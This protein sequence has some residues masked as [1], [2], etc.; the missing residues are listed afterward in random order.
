VQPYFVSVL[1]P[2]RQ[3]GTHWETHRTLVA[4]VL[5]QVKWTAEPV[6]RHYVDAPGP[7]IRTSI[8]GRIATGGTQ[9]IEL[10]TAAHDGIVEAVVGVNGIDR[11]VV[12]PVLRGVTF[13]DPPRSAE[14]PRIVEAYRRL[15]QKQYLDREGGT[16]IAGSLMYERIWLRADG[17]ADFSST[18]PEG[19]AASP[20]PLK[21]DP[22][23]MEGDYGRWKAVGDQVHV[24]RRP[25]AA[26]E[27]FQRENGGLKRGGQWW[28]PMPR[29]DDLK[30]AGRWGRRSQPGE[31]VSPYHDWIEFRPDGSFATQGVLRHVA[32]GLVDRPK[33]AERASGTYRI[34]DWTIFFS[35]DDGTTWSTDF[36]TIGRD[37]PGASPILLWATA[38]PR[39]R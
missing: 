15:E 34:R 1:P 18:Y 25:D 14:R 35:F 32:S 28:E 4:T 21:V 3:T 38:Y 17:V 9:S 19:Y 36:S 22:G 20:L 16:P 5:A 31:T 13:R 6:T 33:P 8:A 30:L 11:N 26:P 10:Y 12:D 24:F 23:L 2:T 7:F 37:P 29:V 27:I 39:E